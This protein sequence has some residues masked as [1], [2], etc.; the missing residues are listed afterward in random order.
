MAKKSNK[1]QTKTSK[2]NSSNVENFMMKQQGQQAN[3]YDMGI[4][5]RLKAAQAPSLQIGVS[6]RDPYRP[7]SED[8][9]TGYV[10]NGYTAINSKS[11]SGTG[12]QNVLSNPYAPLSSQMKEQQAY[13]FYSQSVQ[14]WLNS[15]TPGYK[16]IDPNNPYQKQLDSL[17]QVSMMQD[18]RNPLAA[19]KAVRA[20]NMSMPKSMR[21][22][23]IAP[24]SYYGLQAD[25][26][27]LNKQTTGKNDFVTH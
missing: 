24:G 27:Q 2:W 6:G 19:Q 3:P 10:V 14:D 22:M 20:A 23:D 4:G 8:T 15:T 16:R 18:G 11:T 1:D 9:N 21:P 12:R 17:V 5:E 25:E 13:D 26:Y 7:Y